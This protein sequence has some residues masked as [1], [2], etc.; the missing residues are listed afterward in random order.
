[1]KKEKGRREKGEGRAR[2]WKL[3]DPKPKGLSRPPQIHIVSCTSSCR[4]PRDKRRE[5]EGGRRK[6]EPFG[7]WVASRPPCMTGDRSS[8]QMKERTA[9]SIDVGG[10]SASCSAK[11]NPKG[12]CESFPPSPQ[13]ESKSPKKRKTSPLS[14]KT[15]ILSCFC[16]P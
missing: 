7:P 9:P 15:S 12:K 1:M 10:P 5:E 4:N 6:R 2:S 11:G 16:F 8:T 13:R 3:E 14:S